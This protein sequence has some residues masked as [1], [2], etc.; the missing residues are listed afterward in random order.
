MKAHLQPPLWE[1]MPIPDLALLWEGMPIP[2][3]ALYRPQVETVKS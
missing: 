2:D 1:G 3:L